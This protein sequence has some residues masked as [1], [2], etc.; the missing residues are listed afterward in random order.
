MSTTD[1]LASAQRTIASLTKSHEATSLREQAALAEATALRS[2]LAEITSRA[3]LADAKYEQWLKRHLAALARANSLPLGAGAETATQLR[4]IV[5]EVVEYANASHEKHTA[6]HAAR[7]A[8]LSHT[9]G[10]FRAFLAFA[11]DELPACDLALDPAHQPFDQ[12]VPRL[13]RCLANARDRYERCMEPVRDAEDRVADLTADVVR[14]TRERDV[15]VAA[16][17]AV[18]A[19][20]LAVVHTDDDDLAA[21]IPLVAPVAAA[22]AAPILPLVAPAAHTNLP[23]AAPA[24]P[25]LAPRAVKRRGKKRTAD[26]ACVEEG[27]RF[28]SSGSQRRLR[29]RH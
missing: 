29:A 16:V 1:A 7:D 6:I 8:Q 5:E 23:P 22:L 20:A 25:V 15:L 3:A 26:E 19:E 2:Q 10:G 11:A 18:R 28:A 21:A 9:I 4:A 24:V 13:Q 14:L 27:L 17:A 12:L